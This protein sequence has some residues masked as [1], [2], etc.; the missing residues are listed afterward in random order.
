MRFFLLST[1][2]HIVNKYLREHDKLKKKKRI[3]QDNNINSI[4]GN[5]M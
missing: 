2:L 3:K 4:P 1:L 5:L